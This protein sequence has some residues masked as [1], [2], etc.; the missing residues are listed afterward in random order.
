MKYIVLALVACHLF[1]QG[2]DKK[3][4]WY[5]GE[6]PWSSISKEGRQEILNL[7]AGFEAA[8]SQ[9]KKPASSKSPQAT[10]GKGDELIR[11]TVKQYNLDPYYLTPS[12]F[13]KKMVIWLPEK[14]WKGFSEADKKAIEASVKSKYQNWGIGVGRTKGREVLSDRIVKES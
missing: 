1:A 14:A 11:R 13:G 10:S 12:L 2:V 3:P 8:E 9:A 4:S 7:H 6:K 5:T